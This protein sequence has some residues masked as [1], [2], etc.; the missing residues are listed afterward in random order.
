MM[1]PPVTPDEDTL[2]EIAI[3]IL[4]HPNWTF[5]KA[6]RQAIKTAPPLKHSEDSCRR[7]LHRKFGVRRDYWLNRGREELEARRKIQI[8]RNLENVAKFMK[9]IDLSINSHPE[10]TAALRF[11]EQ[12][13][14]TVRIAQ[15][16]AEQMGPS[17][18]ATQKVAEHMAPL[19]QMLRHT[20]HSRD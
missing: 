5:S 15:K 18:R 14:P 8:Q 4:M 16:I 11:A 10:L 12:M 20:S 1:A 13:T 6:Y 17:I 7:R 2:L 19:M 9:Q 3:T